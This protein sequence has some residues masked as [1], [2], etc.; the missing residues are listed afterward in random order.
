M[1][2][3]SLLLTFSRSVSIWLVWLSVAVLHLFL[4]EIATLWI[5]LS[6]T[7]PDAIANVIRPTSP[8]TISVALATIA[9]YGFLLKK[10]AAIA[11]RLIRAHAQGVL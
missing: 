11:H 3:I 7:T 5:W 4:A 2:E 10:L 9:G 6:G 1:N 8:E